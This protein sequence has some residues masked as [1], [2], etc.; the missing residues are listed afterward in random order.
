MAQADMEK[1]GTPSGS[2]TSGSDNGSRIGKSFMKKEHPDT[3]H[4][5]YPSGEMHGGQKMHGVKHDGNVKGY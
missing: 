2:E 1:R 4:K 5:K 3:G